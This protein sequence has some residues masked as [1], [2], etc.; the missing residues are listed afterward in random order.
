[1]N[2]DHKK[3][4]FLEKEHKYLKPTVGEEH[5]SKIYKIG[6]YLA[7]WMLN[8][9]KPFLSNDITNDD[10]LQGLKI[11]DSGIHSILRVPIILRGKLIGVINLFNKSA[12]AQFLE[13]GQKLMCIIA[14]QVASFLS[15]A[16]HQD[17]SLKSLESAVQNFIK[18]KF[19]KVI[20]LYG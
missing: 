6:E 17:Y 14:T 1:M 2:F 13:N 5:Q 11:E 12:A 19:L 18:K 9:R 3:I 4:R 10:R 7:S 16:N 8:N 20:N 15:G